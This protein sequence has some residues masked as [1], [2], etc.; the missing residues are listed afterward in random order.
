MVNIIL[1]KKTGIRVPGL[2][3]LEEEPAFE[4]IL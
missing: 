4:S 2:N 3:Y 1:T